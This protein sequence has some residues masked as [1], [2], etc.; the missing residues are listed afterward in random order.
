MSKELSTHYNDSDII[1]LGYL[2]FRQRFFRHGQNIKVFDIYTYQQWQTR[3][4]DS[5]KTAVVDLNHREANERILPQFIRDVSSHKH[6]DHETLYL[7]SSAREIVHLCIEEGLEPKNLLLSYKEAGLN[8]LS[9]HDFVDAI[10]GKDI[11]LSVWLEVH[12]LAH[13]LGILS[14]ASLYPDQELNFERLSQALQF[15]NDLQGM[16]RGFL[17]LDLPDKGTISEQLKLLST[18]RNLAQNIHDLKIDIRS[19]NLLSA[20]VKFAF[21]ANVAARCAGGEFDSLNRTDFEL[22]IKKAQGI[23]I[24]F[25]AFSLNEQK[26]Q[27]FN[28][29]KLYR[30]N[31]TSQ[32]SLEQ[33]SEI[34][35]SSPLPAIATSIPEKE[36]RADFQKLA[37]I[38]IDLINEHCP[39]PDGELAFDFSSISEGSAEV[40]PDQLDR[41]CDYIQ[42]NKLQGRF[43]AIGFRGIW[44]LCHSLNID[45]DDFASRMAELGITRVQSSQSEAEEALT[46]SEVFDLHQSFHKYQIETIGKVELSA[47]YNGA[48]IP[49]W[50]PFVQR[51]LSLNSLNEE[52]NLLKGLIVQES[53]N[54]FISIKEYLKAVAISR[55][56]CSGAEEIITPIEYIGQGVMQPKIKTKKEFEHISE[57][58]SFFGASSLGLT[59]SSPKFEG[60]VAN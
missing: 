2:A 25:E 53:R 58:L 24:E 35:S 12:Q 8:I 34:V 10:L 14:T 57:L 47:P 22:N 55:L 38:S 6:G 43:Q 11:N 31:N 46:N 16:K 30:L 23:P 28:S 60:S 29:M 39:P 50:E 40:L 42:T 13:E 7:G 27:T 45:L 1:E 59:S 18:V 51:L 19:E 49:F 33:I 20:Q 54:S 21:G 5:Q 52:N 36:A 32:H 17:Y 15:I 9:G 26:A 37:T 3:S 4:S 48:G 41:L 56:V 44:Q